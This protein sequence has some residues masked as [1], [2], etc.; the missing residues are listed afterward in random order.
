M[1]SSKRK[2]NLLNTLYGCVWSFL[3]FNDKILY[4]EI[5]DNWKY[6]EISYVL[7]SLLLGAEAS[8]GFALNIKQPAFT[9]KVENTGVCPSVAE[10]R[11]S[12]N[13]M[14][15]KIHTLSTEISHHGRTRV[16]QKNENKPQYQAFWEAVFVF[17]C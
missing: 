12:H 5:Q 11:D 7:S 10:V 4:F 14:S 17:K 15:T 3:T 13:L 6:D 2:I 9:G 8:N 1:R 16:S